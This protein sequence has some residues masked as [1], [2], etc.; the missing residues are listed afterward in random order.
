VNDARLLALREELE[1]LVDCGAIESYSISPQT[2][3]GSVVVSEAVVQLL[4]AGVDPERD[5]DYWRAIQTD[6]DAVRA[7]FERALA[8]LINRSDD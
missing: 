1:W 5:P 2:G 6:P 7:W 8:G 3:L 4:I